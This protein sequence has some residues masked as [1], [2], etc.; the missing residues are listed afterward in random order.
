MKLNT[1]HTR[2]IVLFSLVLGILLLVACKT[3]PPG[4]RSQKPTSPAA[5]LVTSIVTTTD[6]LPSQTAIAR[7]TPSLTSVPSYT[8]KPTSTRNP[9]PTIDPF[10]LTGP[11]PQTVDVVRFILGHHPDFAYPDPV[12]LAAHYREIASQ[13]VRQ[14]IDVN[15][16]GRKEILLTDTF[17]GLFG[18]SAILTLTPSHPPATPSVTWKEAFYLQDSANPSI[19]MRF[20]LQRDHLELDEYLADHG[21]GMVF[22]TW[23]KNW[24][25]CGQDNCNLVWTGKLMGLAEQFQYNYSSAA[26]TIARLE[27]PNPDTIELTIQSWA[28]GIDDATDTA[29]LVAHRISGPI[30]RETYQWN[31]KIYQFIG[32]TE[33]APAQE[34]TRESDHQTVQTTA[35]INTLLWKKYVECAGTICRNDSRQRDIDFWGTASSLKDDPVWGGTFYDPEWGGLQIVPAAASRDGNRLAAV[36][37]SKKYDQCR[38]VVHQLGDNE[39]TPV[40]RVDLPCVAT[41]THLSWLDIDNDGNNELALVTVPPDAPGTQRLYLYRVG[42]GLQELAHLD[43]IINGPDGVG[44]KWDKT[45]GAYK[46]YAGIVPTD[47]CLQ[48][49]CLFLDRRFQT[50]RWNAR[51]DQFELDR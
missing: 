30:A 1:K 3:D 20:S 21:T 17:D 29:P 33:L 28:F 26:W 41:F 2:L 45:N 15:G 44:I 35:F 47:N 27:Y 10:V 23:K 8:P 51:S 16:D 9:T 25:R 42:P 43:G 24:I 49:D 37:S 50:Y 4:T 31:G 40:G 11:N 32:Q 39:F 14:D 19:T 22:R 38:L 13:S 18:F 7:A 12:Y 48:F 6:V 46:F 5:A 34:I 36:L